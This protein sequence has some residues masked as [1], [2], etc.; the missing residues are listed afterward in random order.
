MR[1]AGLL[2]DD[3]RCPR[4]PAAARPARRARGAAPTPRDDAA[5][6]RPS[7]FS[8]RSGPTI[9]SSPGGSARHSCSASA[10]CTA[11]RHDGSADDRDPVGRRHD[12]GRARR[13]ARGAS[14]QGCG[15]RIAVAAGDAQRARGLAR[16]DD[17]RVA[18]AGHAAPD[19][20]VAR[21]EGG[22]VGMPRPAPRAVRASWRCDDRRRHAARA[23][24]RRRPP[25]GAGRGARRARRPARSPPAISGPSAGEPQREHRAGD[26][27]QHDG[28][29]E[30]DHGAP[31]SASAA[32]RGGV[33][34]AGRVSGSSSSSASIRVDGS[35]AGDET[36]SG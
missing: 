18:A 11:C 22:D 8:P 25:H 13:A 29:D 9:R 10:R 31:R 2:P 36:R 12:D 16:A 33:H 19:L 24:R 34:A 20:A 26:E 30:R 5:A 35:A 4:P 21:D 7:A 23:R 6:A 28:A 1:R 32:S 15:I 27:P 17:E 3:E 14:A